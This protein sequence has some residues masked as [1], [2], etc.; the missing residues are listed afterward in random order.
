M[1]ANRQRLLVRFI[2]STLFVALALGI[3][4][5]MAFRSQGHASDVISGQR[6]ILATGWGVGVYEM[7]ENDL[8]RV[9]DHAFDAWVKRAYSAQFSAADSSVY[10]STSD[11]AW[12][13]SAKQAVVDAPE[14]W[15]YV[16]KLDEKDEPMPVTQGSH[17][18]VSPDGQSL[19]VIRNETEIWH[20]KLDASEAEFLVGKRSDYSNTLWLSNTKL[21]FEESGGELVVFDTTNSSIVRTGVTGLIPNSISPDQKYVLCWALGALEIYLL[22]T[23]DFEVETIVTG[24]WFGLGEHFVWSSDG[25]G[26]LY[27]RTT[28]RHWKYLFEGQDMYFHTLE[29]LDYFAGKDFMLYSGTGLR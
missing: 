14:T 28:L 2:F 1:D 22:D 13:K 24:H 25:K 6:F 15:I 7:T 18:A 21:L 12:D 19:A 17:P 8:V 10:F 9:S 26:F 27:S 4:L 29:G 23:E 11:K 3:F 20:R 5:M 16:T